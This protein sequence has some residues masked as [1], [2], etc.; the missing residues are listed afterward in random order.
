MT[1]TLC[2]KQKDI[3]K[4]VHDASYNFISFQVVMFLFVVETS[5]VTGISVRITRAVF[6]DNYIVNKSSSEDLKLV[7]RRMVPGGLVF[8]QRL[9]SIP[10]RRD[11]SKV[12]L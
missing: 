10:G 6:V 12:P 2:C 5:Q 1:P 9:Q 3:T 4:Q 8:T 7:G 11:C